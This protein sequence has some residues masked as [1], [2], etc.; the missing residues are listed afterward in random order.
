M[1]KPY[2][3]IYQII[4]ASENMVIFHKT[5]VLTYYLIDKK[6]VWVSHK[7]NFLAIY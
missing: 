7:M 3:Y 4:L 5:F 6:L 2:H 1:Q